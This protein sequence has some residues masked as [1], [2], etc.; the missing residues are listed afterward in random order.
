MTTLSIKLPSH[1]D[2]GAESDPQQIEITHLAARELSLADLQEAR[3]PSPGVVILL[4][5]SDSF[6]LTID[7]EPGLMVPGVAQVLSGNS[8][9]GVVPPASA[10]DGETTHVSVALVELNAVIN[11]AIPLQELLGLPRHLNTRASEEAER[12]CENLVCHGAELIL[13]PGQPDVMQHLIAVRLVALLLTSAGIPQLDK[14]D[15]QWD[16]RILKLKTFLVNNMGF[17]PTTDEMAVHMGMSRSSFYRWA[18]P[19]LGCSPVQYLRQMRLEKSQELLHNTSL[20]IER[21]AECTGFS[22]RQHMWQEFSK[23]FQITP[24]QL[25]RQI[26][27]ISQDNP[28]DK[29]ESL[30]RQHRFEEALTTCKSRLRDTPAGHARDQILEQQARCLYAMGKINEAVET[31]E[32]MLKGPWAIEAGQQLCSHHYRCGNYQQASEIF[33]ELFA[34]AT[35]NQRHDLIMSWCHQVGGLVARR[36]S[37]PLPDYLNVRRH[38]FP[39]NV[40]S[41]SVTAEALKGLGQENRVMKECPDLH[42]RHMHALR[43]AGLFHLGIEGTEAGTEGGKATSLMFMGQYAEAMELAPHDPGLMAQALTRLGRASEA[44]A[45]YPDHCQE[46]YL[47]LGKYQELLDRWPEPSEH[48]VLALSALNR[49][50]TLRDYPEQ[51]GTLW[52]LAQF[53]LGPDHFLAVRK[54]RQPEFHIPALCWKAVQ[55][56]AAGEA[57]QADTFLRKIPLVQSADYWRWAEPSCNE[58]SLTTITRGL[59]GKLDLAQAE[60]KRIVEKLKYTDYQCMWHDAAFLLGAIDAEAYKHQPCQANVENRL[61]LIMI[62]KD[63]LDNRGTAESYHS[64]LERLSGFYLLSRP[65]LRAFLNWRLQSLIQERG[66]D[67]RVR[68]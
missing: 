16:D 24:A 30:I 15:E 34:K 20:S 57:E 32:A 6:T 4:P 66:P 38:Y 29:V 35:E 65:Q 5:Q 46:A 51:H 18:A 10:E 50:E 23:Q 13:S 2:A 21:I 7:D 40:R 52:Y 37:G 55:L 42:G 43:R 54:P 59:A 48:Q 33:A 58:T 19:L 44:V 9:W 1:S 36:I 14:N 68:L 47:V 56:L 49:A 8:A 28:L 39:G 12:L 67:F 60:L 41:M 61:A 22:S 27:R 45:C 31:W 11:D 3:S 17:P 64:L 26:K 53:H 25:R 62:L 63:D